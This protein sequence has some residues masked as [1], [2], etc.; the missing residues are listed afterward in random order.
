M[1][2]LLEMLVDPKEGLG[3]PIECDINPMTVVAQGAA[4][5]AATQQRRPVSSRRTPIST[6]CIQ[7]QLEYKPV[8]AD[9]EP[10]IGGKVVNPPSGSL[11]G[12]TIEFFNNEAK[13][14]WRSGKVR[15]SR[16]GTFMT[17]LWAERGRRNTF[18]IELLGPTG[19]R[20]STEPAEIDYMVAVEPAKS[21]LPHNIGIAMA[22]NKVDWFFR[23]GAELPLIV[24]NR[25]H[26]TTEELRRGQSGQRIRIPVVEGLDIAEADLNRAI[27]VM[28]LNASDIPRDVPIGSDVE[29]TLAIDESRI[30]TGS[31]YIPVID[32]VIELGFDRGD[33]FKR[34]P[35]PK[36]LGEDV[37][38]Q[39]RRVD[40]MARGAGVNQPGS[41]SSTGTELSQIRD[42]LAELERQLPNSHD[43][44][45]LFARENELLDLKRKLAAIE[46]KREVPNLRAEAQQEIAWTEEAVQAH[47]SQEDQRNWELLKQTINKAMD[48]DPEALRQKVA[49]AY[50]MRIG[51]AV[52][53]PWWW[54]RLYEYLETRR[55]DMTD[56]ELAS[57]WFPH[58]EAAI[59]NGDFDGLKSGCRQL[60][61]LLPIEE[62][63]RGYGGTTIAKSAA[64]ASSS[65]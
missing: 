31:A 22:N 5:F 45:A 19:R 33:F 11:E 14:A 35:N 38:R 64:S 43:H 34:T 21:P 44:D 32:E 10:L 59:A 63:Q 18:A 52:G 51:L 24:K 49:A 26:S 65:V 37:T 47:G 60:W 2:H 54:V 9:T 57:T 56:S 36:I 7:L 39:R 25:L 1:P 61:A 4:V 20:C 40:E 3:I 28:E 13:P 12:Y 42:A 53:Q 50:D 55:Q 30:L 62:Q 8:A 23:K 29:I 27:G 6:D 48:G 15:L 41:F 16:E 46:K 58:V 17:S